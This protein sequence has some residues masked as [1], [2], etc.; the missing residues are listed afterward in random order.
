[1]QADAMMHSE[2]F[3]NASQEYQ[4]AYIA[5]VQYYREIL[6]DSAN[7][8]SE[9]DYQ[10]GV[11]SLGELQGVFTGPTTLQSQVFAVG[12]SQDTQQTATMLENGKG[13]RYIFGDKYGRIWTDFTSG[14]PQYHLVASRDSGQGWGYVEANIKVKRETLDN[15]RDKWTVT[16]FPEKAFNSGNPGDKGGNGLVNA[17]FGNGLTSDYNVV[18]TVK[19]AVDTNP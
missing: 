6:S 5:A 10:Y 18:S 4:V 7:N 3:Q 8:L 13:G 16:F 2:G 12:A 11:A 9:E 15:G 14:S 19:I 17:K 1:M